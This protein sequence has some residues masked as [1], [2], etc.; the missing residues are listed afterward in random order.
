MVE[1]VLYLFCLQKERGVATVLLKKSRIWQ[2]DGH[3]ISPGT[4]YGTLSKKKDRKRWID[5]LCSWGRKKTLFYHG[6]W[7]ADFRVKSIVER[8]YRN[9]K[10][11]VWWKENCHIKSLPLQTMMTEKQ[12][13]LKMHSQSW[14]LKNKL[15]SLSCCSSLYTANPVRL[16]T[17]PI[18]VFAHKEGGQALVSTVWGLCGS[19]LQTLINFLFS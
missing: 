4:M 10:E 15:F 2:K 8:L 16:R 12:L 11:E 19:I 3:P 13:I 7:E 17:W 9:S 14:K 18:S 1:Q 6:S 5:C